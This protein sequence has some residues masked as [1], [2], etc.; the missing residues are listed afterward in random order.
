MSEWW[1]WLVREVP[2]VAAL[3]C[4]PLC[5]AAVV[6]VLS[7]HSSV[8]LAGVLS[9]VTFAALTVVNS[10]T[11]R[12]HASTSSLWHWGLLVTLEVIGAYSTYTM[13]SQ[14]TGS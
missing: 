9:V 4:L 13:F 11:A 12:A 8:T 14:A 6:D 3:N 7:L 10:R 2:V 5:V 1:A